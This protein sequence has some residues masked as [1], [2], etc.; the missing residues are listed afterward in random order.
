MTEVH[1]RFPPAARS[2]PEA[3]RAVSATLFEWG[4]D[5]LVDTVVLLASEIVTNAVLHA[6]TDLTVSVSTEGSGVRV[7]VL[8]GS[9][10]PPALR[11]HSAT[12]TTGRGIQL[13]DMLA[14]SWQ[15][16][17]SPQ[18]KAVWFTVS[19]ERDPWAA[20]AGGVEADR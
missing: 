4:M 14:D 17:L 20:F 6:R 11:H 8:D 19:S 10:V 18:G 7:T 2:V 16:E 12:S 15:A 9:P 3:R 1:W 13:L 5:G